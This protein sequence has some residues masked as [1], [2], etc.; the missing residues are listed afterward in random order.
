MKKRNIKI[1][2]ESLINVEGKYSLKWIIGNKV[3]ISEVD[4]IVMVSFVYGWNKLECILL[5]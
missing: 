1:E 2:T 4:I 5:N 3:M